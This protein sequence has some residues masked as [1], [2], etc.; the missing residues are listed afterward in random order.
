MY[1]EPE[2]TSIGLVDDVVARRRFLLPLVPLLPIIRAKA[3]L[4]PPL[5]FFLD[6]ELLML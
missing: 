3:S 4:P 1:L 6:D 5:R 2:P